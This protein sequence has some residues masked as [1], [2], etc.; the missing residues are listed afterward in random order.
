MSDMTHHFGELLDRLII[1]IGASVTA[2]TGGVGV[3]SGADWMVLLSALVGVLTVIKLVVG[4]Y[5]DV[6]KHRR[7]ELNV[8]AGGGAVGRGRRVDD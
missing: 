3:L 5:V 7:A 4:I 8:R 1:K 2:M 6:A